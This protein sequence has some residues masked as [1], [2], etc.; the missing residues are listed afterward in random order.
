MSAPAPEFLG[1]GWSFPPRADDHGEV[2]LVVGADDVREAIRLILATE[3]GERVMRPDFGCGLRHMLFEPISTTTLALVRHRV[4]QALIAWEPR[5]DVQ[6]VDVTAADAVAGR[7]DV[8]IAY[9]IRATNTFYNLVF[10][11]YLLERRE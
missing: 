7:V 4:E 10:P 3:P 9:R 11:F 5:I 1:R 2:E 8:A 6:S